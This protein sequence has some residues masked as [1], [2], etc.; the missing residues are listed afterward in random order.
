MTHFALTRYNIMTMEFGTAEC[1]SG[2]VSY[3]KV[4][5]HDINNKNTLQQGLPTLGFLLLFFGFVFG[6]LNP[7]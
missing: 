7:F 6:P 1:L 2:H 4:M 5:K 3:V